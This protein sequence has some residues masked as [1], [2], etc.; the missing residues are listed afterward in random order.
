MPAH[1]STLAIDQTRA[2]QFDE[3]QF[4]KFLRDALF[5]RNLRRAHRLL[6][7][8]LPRQFQHRAQSVFGF[9]RNAHAAFPSNPIGII[10]EGISEC[11]H[12][13]SSLSVLSVPS[14]AKDG[15]FFATEVTEGTERTRKGLTVQLSEG[16]FGAQTR[17]G[18][19]DFLH[20]RAAHD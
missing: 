5:L 6:T 8:S 3:Y 10:I 1:R 11:K 4:E 9:L 20:A 14:V 12:S 7:I 15:P 2:A 18:Q 19:I 13:V 17:D 16:L